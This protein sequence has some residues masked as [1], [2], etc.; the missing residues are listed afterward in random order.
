M[1][2]PAAIKI[3]EGHKRARA[4]VF[5][6][7]IAAADKVEAIT[8]RGLLV[9]RAVGTDPGTGRLRWTERS[10]EVDRYLIELAVSGL[11]GRVDL[12][13]GLVG[14]QG[15]LAGCLNE[16]SPTVWAAQRRLMVFMSIFFGTRGLGVCSVSIQ[17][18]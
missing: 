7:Q 8:R 17:R 10:S 1:R 11:D 6:E 14:D 5:H 18:G 9:R 2:I 15:R 3:I 4:I 16:A 12:V 13:E